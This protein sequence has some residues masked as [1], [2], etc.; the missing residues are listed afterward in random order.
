M[1]SLRIDLTA[2]IIAIVVFVIFLWI[3][4]KIVKQL[5]WKTVLIVAIIAGLVYFFWPAISNYS[6]PVYDRAE[7]IKGVEQ[8][9]TEG[10]SIQYI[11]K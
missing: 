3:A 9:E 8:K 7:S 2:L 4:S 6:K 11:P 10:S 1:V 5:T